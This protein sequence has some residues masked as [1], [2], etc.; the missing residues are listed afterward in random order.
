MLKDLFLWYIDNQEE[1][2]KKYEGKFLVIKDNSVV[3]V[4]SDKQKALDEAS[5]KYGLGNFIIQLCSSEEES[6]TQTYHSRVI[7]A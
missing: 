1:L 3:D 5:K 4:Y 6:Y 7:F 2:S